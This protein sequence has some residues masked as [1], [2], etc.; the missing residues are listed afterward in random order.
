[1]TDEPE[2]DPEVNEERLEFLC[3]LLHRTLTVMSQSTCSEKRI[4]LHKL[5]TY[6][7]KHL[8]MHHVP[9]DA[10]RCV[11]REAGHAAEAEMTAAEIEHGVSAAGGDA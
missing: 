2:H 5:W 1:M 9:E 6:E 3:A 8:E 4:A 7:S 11:A 10:A